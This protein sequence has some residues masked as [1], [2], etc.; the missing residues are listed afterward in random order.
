MPSTIFRQSPIDE[1]SRR[2]L[3]ILTELSL[4]SAKWRD[5]KSGGTNPPSKTRKM[6]KRGRILHNSS[7][8][9][10][11]FSAVI[12]SVPKFLGA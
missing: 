4:F 2:E 12:L 10:I 9:S 1:N 7:L 3:Q 11:A 5:Q 6:T 8:L